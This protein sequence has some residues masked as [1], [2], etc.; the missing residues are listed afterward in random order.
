[1]TEKRGLERG[2]TLGAA[3]MRRSAWLLAA[4][5]G[6]LQVLIFPSINW[7]WL[8]WVAF[9]PLLLAI[10]AARTSDS[11]TLPATAGKGFLLAYVSGLVWS[12]GSC[13]WVFHSMHVFGG[14]STGAA[15]GVLVLF[16][17]ALAAHEG[18]FGLLLALV[19]ARG[20][21]R[22]ALVLAPFLWVAVELARTRITGFPWDLLGTVQVDNI[23]LSRIATFTG[24]YGLSFE[25]LLVNAALAAAFLSVPSRRKLL[26]VAAIVAAVILQLGVLVQ[27]GAFPASHTARL[28]QQNIPIMNESDWTPQ[29]FQQT[30]SDLA[31]IS[32]P[33]PGELPPNEPAAHLVVWPESPA[34]FYTTDPNFRRQ[35][36]DIARR[37]NAWMIVGS[38]GMKQP[39]SPGNQALLFN[40][41]AIIS[42]GGDWT[43]R[44]DKIHLV[45]FGEYIPFGSLLS[46][47]HKL[48]REVGQFEPGS[49]RTVYPLDGEKVGVFICYES[50]FPDEVR[51]F[52]RNGAQVFVNISNDG[53]FGRYGAP[54]QHLNQARMRAI[55]NQ[56]WLLRD[57]DTGITASIDPYGRVVAR[58]PREVRTSVDV[59]YDLVAG[60][61]FYTR[62]G[63]WFAFACAIITLLA[64]ILRFRLPAAGAD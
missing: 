9:M 17:L 36:S 53:W 26:L 40:S 56:R 8:S 16:C 33:Q 34:P 48:T 58:A 51:Q 10:L 30:M 15:V 57:T 19:A 31:R 13:Y 38:L 3:R 45:P 7:F 62:H 20:Y 32:A 29:Y 24:V 27:P 22:R 14:L 54:Q 46:F 64:L 55:E 25:V 42:P 2:Y 44:Y 37:A 60:T 49:A 43:A 41:A 21:E 59:P 50:I 35:V 1:M 11:K 5:S 12:A 39:G 47:A 18:I 23:P 28:V 6:G 63:D 61:T 4:V 52:A